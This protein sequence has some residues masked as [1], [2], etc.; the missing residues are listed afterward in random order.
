MARTAIA[1]G[2]VLPVELEQ[3]FDLIVTRRRFDLGSFQTRSGVTLPDV[4]FGWECYG[5][6]NRA[7]DNAILVNHY[8]LGFG[9][10][11]GRYSPDERHP[12]FW[13]DVI[14]PGKL[15][16]TRRFF[17]IT[18]DCLCNVYA[19]HP[20]VVTTGPA[21]RNPRT[22]EPYGPDFPPLSLKDMVAAQK[23]LLDSLG[24][25]RLHAIVG[26]GMGGALAYEYAVAFPDHVARI[27]PLC[28]TAEADGWQIAWMSAWMTPIRLD[29]NWRGGRYHGHTPPDAGLVEA[30]KIIYLTARHWKVVQQSFGRDWLDPAK[31]MRGALT[32]S[33]DAVARALRM[34]GERRARH[35]DANH[36]IWLARANQ[37][38]KVG[39]HESLER[40]LSR[41][42]ARVLAVHT[43]NDQLYGGPGFQD[44]LGIMMRNGT[45]L[46]VIKRKDS[47]GH[48]EAFAR[49]GPIAGAID[50]FL[51]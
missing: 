38:F 18:M 36:L 8:F 32:D 50:D 25:G 29:P 13:D 20:Q 28:A 19:R 31:D 6:L 24:V 33:D 2:S 35:A 22:G 30:M 26:A 14:G 7:G 40:A 48:V 39:E 44:N 51:D 46:R 16:D 43:P 10:A 11:A 27:I 34:A 12:G 45:R 15:F 42:K 49:L 5:E 41:L 1:S 47:H 17:V 9:H 3:E 4:S 37:T 23:A 21:S